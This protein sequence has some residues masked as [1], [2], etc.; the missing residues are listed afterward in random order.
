MLWRHEDFFFS[1]LAGGNHY[2][3]A[4]AAASSE[5]VAAAAAGAVGR[6]PDHRADDAR[7]RDLHAV[8]RLPARLEGRA[9]AAGSTPRRR[10]G[11][12]RPS[13]RWRSRWSA[14]RWPG[15]SRTSWP[16]IPASTT[17]PRCSSLGS[18]GA[19]LSPSV[20]EQLQAPAARACTSPTGSAPPRPA[21]TA[22][23]TAARDGQPRLVHAGNVHVLDEQL[24]PVRPGE[25]GRIAKS[26]HVPLGYYGDEAATRGTF[27]VIDGVALRPARR[28]GPGR[29]GRLDRRA[30]PRLDLHQHRRRE[31]L[32][33][34]GR[35]GAQ[36]APGRARR[37]R[38]RAC[39]TSGSASGSRPWSSCGAGGGRR[40]RRAA[41]ALPGH[42]RR[43]QGAGPDRVRA[44]RRALPHRQGR[45][46]VGPRVL[47]GAAPPDGTSAPAQAATP[48]QAATPAE[49][50]APTQA[51]APAQAGAQAATP[52]KAGTQT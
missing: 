50:A 21:P 16:P 15:R 11:W 44:G 4:A 25:T 37:G 7:R 2:G 49:A 34:G 30:R 39:P 24:R 36:G 42:A 38:G 20:R 43:V 45:L 1:A 48:V 6:L 14:T 28:P 32:P 18:G 10:C 3:A 46:P 31:G 19:L 27:P 12:S 47:A 9:S 5:I 22:S 51:G 41:R 40:R 29:G 52:A 13:R 23:S 26:G 17:C 35:A 33:R 8:L